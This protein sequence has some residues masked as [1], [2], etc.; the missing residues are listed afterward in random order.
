MEIYWTGNPAECS[1]LRSQDIATINSCSEPLAYHPSALKCKPGTLCNLKHQAQQ[2]MHPVYVTLVTANKRNEIKVF[3]TIQDLSLVEL[4]E[5][6]QPWMD[7]FGELLCKVKGHVFNWLFIFILDH[8]DTDVDIECSPLIP[9][10]LP[11][12]IEGIMKSFSS[13]ITI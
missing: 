10:P 8:Q 5:M 9:P 7:G 1:T 2:H 4:N 6:F 13:Y 12:T 3:C 11:S